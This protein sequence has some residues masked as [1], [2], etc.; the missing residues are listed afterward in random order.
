MNF[1]IPS[2]E[3]RFMGDD[4]L[5]FLAIGDGLVK[6]IKT[7]S[8]FKSD[9][10]IVDV[11]SGY[12]RLAHA[13]L[14][15]NF[16]GTYHGLEILKPHNDWAQ[17]NLGNEKFRFSHLDIRNSRYNPGGSVRAEDVKLQSYAERSDLIVLT[18]V[19]THMYE[20][21]IENYLT[22]FREMLHP[23]GR[24]VCSFFLL[25]AERHN[26]MVEGTAKL[27]LPFRLSPVAWYHN[28]SD[29][30]HAIAFEQAWVEGLIQRKGF[31]VESI[32]YGHWCDGH[33]GPEQQ[34]QDFVVLKCA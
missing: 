15:S 2:K 34:Y 18:S 4:E 6:S 9:A 33:I 11:G 29:P 27:P 14:R 5:S 22:C 25:N 26:A 16:C 10:A 31:T 19:F 1:P 28:A 20:A 17:E 21:E 30:L 23:S 24:I 3:L 7:L 32:S 13:L 8:G 12:G